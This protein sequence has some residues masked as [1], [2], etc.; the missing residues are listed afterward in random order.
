MPR[1][2][3]KAL[4]E[5]IDRIAN[6]TE[7]NKEYKEQN[8][9][10]NDK[11]ENDKIDQNFL[12]LRYVTRA[13]MLLN[14]GRYD[15]SRAELNQS[16]AK[17]EAMPS[18]EFRSLV[19]SACYNTLGSLSILTYRITRD[20]SRTHE[21]FRQGDYY[22]TQHPYTASSPLSSAGVASY[23]N[24]IGHPP[25]KGEFE[26]FIEAI[27]RCIPHTTH[28]INGHLGG[29]DSLCRAEL[30]FYKG[31]LPGAETHAREAVSRARDKGQYGIENRGLFYLLRIHLYNGNDP[32]GL[33]TW[34][35]MEAQ[36]DIQEY[37]NRYTIHDIITGWF[38]TQIG[39][40]EEIAPWL[41][42]EVE[43]NETNLLVIHSFETMV[44]AKS[45]YAEKRCEEALNFIRRK[46]VRGGLGSFH[47][48]LLEITVLEAAI[49][50]R[51][52]DEAGA[53]KTLEEAYAI[54]AAYSLDMPFIELG[55]DMRIMAAAAL[56]SGKYALPKPWLEMIRNKASVYGKKLIAVAEHFRNDRRKVPFLSSQEL[57]I[58]TGISRGFTREKIAGDVSL[59]ISSV[60]N[61]I[62]TIYG[63]LG[64]LNRADAIRIATGLGILKQKKGG[65]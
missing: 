62:K 10:E 42:N 60:K 41:R 20:I 24:L 51:M 16:I 40:I 35:Q 61:I 56:N 4:L 37:V 59:S 14:L 55:E 29:M 2:A 45:L 28:G 38:Y 19:L 33:E 48:G 11:N 9:N 57:S 47:L 58:L 22:Y 27:A 44:K 17:F 32:S 52:G 5:I 18:S 53:L 31:D 12:F 6:N 43:E 13:G 65:K 39:E 34:R 54:S 30:A 23:A 36:L 49:L 15:E 50:W 7:Q 64:A 46:D 8:D 21:Y 3:A 1:S 25:R 63:K 26:E